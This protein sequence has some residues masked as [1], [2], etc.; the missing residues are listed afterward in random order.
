MSISGLRYYY[1]FVCD[2]SVLIFVIL[3]FHCEP[4]WQIPHSLT[5]VTVLPWTCLTDPFTA[6]HML[7]CYHEPVW[8]IPSQPDTCYCVTV[9]LCDRS[10]HSLT[11]VT[12]LPWTCLTDPFTAWHMLLCFSEPVWQIPSQPDSLLLP[13]TCL[14]DPF[15]AWHV[16]VTANLSDRSLNSLTRYCY[17]EPV[18]QIPSQPD[19]CYLVTANLSDRSLHSLTHVT[20]LPRTCLT[21]PFTAWHM[22]LCYRNLSDSFLHSLTYIIFSPHFK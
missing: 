1:Y 22:L 16:T 12:V 6:W 10:L 4:V 9:N 5:H 2:F 18:W 3:P 19:T 8:Q 15:T 21:D 17:R 20:L 7:L 11:H 13:R 14:T